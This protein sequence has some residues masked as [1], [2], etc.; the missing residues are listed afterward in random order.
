MRSR[1]L[2]RT[3]WLNLS[4]AHLGTRQL[5]CGSC[6]CSAYHG[7]EAFQS[8][9]L[10]SVQRGRP[11]LVQMVEEQLSGGMG[12]DVDIGE[13]KALARALAAA[14]PTPRTRAAHR[15]YRK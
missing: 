15:R 12:I 5:D 8:R 14:G 4:P 1:G 7:L 2:C 3:R 13:V 10:G 11:P 6:S 9:L